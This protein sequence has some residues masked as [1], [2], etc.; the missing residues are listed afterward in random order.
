MHLF[1]KE[2]VFY[3]L[4]FRLLSVYETLWGRQPWNMVS[5]DTISLKPNE[6]VAKAAEY[7]K[8]INFKRDTPK[9]IRGRLKEITDKK[10]ALEGRDEP[11]SK[12]IKAMTKPYSE[13]APEDRLELY[14]SDCMIK[15]NLIL[16]T[17]WQKMD[18]L[19]FQE[20]RSSHPCM[21]KPLKD[22]EIEADI[23]NM[24]EA[25]DPPK[26]QRE[27]GRQISNSSAN[28]FRINS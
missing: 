19:W 28:L 2:K 22:P 17:Q 26:Q 11:N 13:L 24:N 23:Q 12:F 27:H 21:K 5:K 20:N 18:T 7:T 25:L 3:I 15:R 8:K 16:A 14:E 4:N 1:G 10:R 6:V 9:P